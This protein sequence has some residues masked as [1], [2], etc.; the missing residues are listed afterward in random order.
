MRCTIDSEKD[1]S[2][3][4]QARNGN[5]DMETG[6]RSVHMVATSWRGQKRAEAER[7]GVKGWRVSTYAYVSCL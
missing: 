2:I 6:E 5:R 4:E 7:Q 3:K 1:Q